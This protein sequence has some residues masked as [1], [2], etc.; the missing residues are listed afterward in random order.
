MQALLF[1]IA[2][3]AAADNAVVSFS[4]LK[5]VDAVIE[6]HGSRVDLVVTR[7]HIAMRDTIEVETEK[8]LRVVVEDYNFDGY[9]DFSVSHTDD[10]MGSYEISEV[11][12]YSANEGKFIRL[13]P[14]CGEEF[15]NLRIE[16]KKRRLL[17]TYTQGNRFRTCAMQY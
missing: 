6:V 16:K 15:V 10:G 1:G 7:L 3:Q 11:F 13:A 4:P 8:T 9:S 5:G 2:F 17:N 12:T 14:T